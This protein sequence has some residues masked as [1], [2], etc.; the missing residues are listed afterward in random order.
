MRDD[1]SGVELPENMADVKR[2]VLEQIGYL[3]NANKWAMDNPGVQPD[4][5]GFVRL[6]ELA[7]RLSIGG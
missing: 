7:E 1:E 3:A 6:V 4:V 2:L 5:I